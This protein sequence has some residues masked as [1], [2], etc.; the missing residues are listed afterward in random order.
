MFVPAAHQKDAAVLGAPE[1][2]SWPMLAARAG[3][4]GSTCTPAKGAY[5]TG[6]TRG[7]LA[8]GVLIRAAPPPQRAIEAHPPRTLT[9]SLVPHASTT[10]RGGEVG[11]R[12][13]AGRGHSATTPANSSGAWAG[14]SSCGHGRRLPRGRECLTAGWR[15]DR[16]VTGARQALSV[17]HTVGSGCRVKAGRTGTGLRCA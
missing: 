1:G 9:A 7:V 10:R 13:T 3:M 8:R 5:D 15:H 14:P 6:A 12:T 2:S 11:R 17:G 16:R 4:S